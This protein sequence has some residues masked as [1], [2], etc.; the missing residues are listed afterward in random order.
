M[1]IKKTLRV[2]PQGHKYQKSSDCPACPV[3]E[4][5]RKPAADF[6]LALGAPARRALEGAGITSLAK[7][8]QYTEK[9]LLQL[10]GMGPSSLPKLRQALK[11]ENR[12]F[13][14]EKK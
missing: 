12:S 13:K 6:M 7:L 3:C 4:K 8:A 11:N 5:L 2:C 1:K 10:H 9:E 14:T